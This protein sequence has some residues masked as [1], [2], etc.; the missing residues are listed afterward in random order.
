MSKHLLKRVEII[1]I[2]ASAQGDINAKN[3]F[4]DCGKVIAKLAADI[5]NITH[6]EL[7]ELIKKLVDMGRFLDDNTK[8]LDRKYRDD[9]AIWLDLTIFFDSG[10]KDINSKLYGVKY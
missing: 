4:E 2:Q 3:F 10:K 1:K 9:P 7:K 8:L 6:D 5:S